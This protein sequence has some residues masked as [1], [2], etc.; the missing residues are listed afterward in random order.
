M[1]CVY[2]TLSDSAQIIDSD[3]V[4]NILSTITTLIHS[5]MCQFQVGC[6]HELAV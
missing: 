1:Q 5:D 2:V 3:P 6:P 4:V